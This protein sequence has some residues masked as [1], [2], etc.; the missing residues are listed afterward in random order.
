MLR[1]GAFHLNQDYVRCAYRLN[2]D[3]DYRYYYF[4]FRVVVSPFL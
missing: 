1:G 3:P 2:F 4:G